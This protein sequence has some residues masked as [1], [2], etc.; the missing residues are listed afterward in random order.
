MPELAEV[1]YYCSR[2]NPGLG[3]RILR[4]HMNGQK[5]CFRGVDASQLAGALSGNR[6]VSSHTHGKRMLFKLDQ[7]LWLGI[8]LGMT[9][10]LLIRRKEAE[11]EKHDHLALE[12]RVAWLVFN[13]PRQFGRIEHH[14]SKGL[15]E[16]WRNLPPETISERFD[17][18]HFRRFAEKGAKQPLKSALLD[19]SRFP[20]VGNWMADE[21]LWH[22]RIRPQRSIAT[23]N[24]H[25]LKD[26][27]RAI[28][29]VSR[30]AMKRIAPDFS[31]PPKSWLFHRRWKAG[32]LCPKTGAHLNR[33]SIGGRT[34]CWSKA[35]QR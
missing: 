31:D 2:W 19:Q 35:W 14:E 23:L 33:D 27:F 30:I 8:H 32:G 20:G 25:E 7:G 24:E 9:G 22:S 26:L 3:E 13:D 29:R 17:F 10:S 15:P 34:T 1:A 21:I 12:T 5:R 4:V 18:Q 16:F 6:L 11:L 28:K